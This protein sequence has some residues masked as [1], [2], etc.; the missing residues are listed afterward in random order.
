MMDQCDLQSPLLELSERSFGRPKLVLLGSIV[1]NFAS[2]AETMKT[3]KK[4]DL[5]ARLHSVVPF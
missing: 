2:V 3:K 5:M 4:G 1:I